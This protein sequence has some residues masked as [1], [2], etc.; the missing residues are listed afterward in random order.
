MTPFQKLKHFFAFRCYCSI[1][2]KQIL[3]SLL[4]LGGIYGLGLNFD[5]LSSISASTA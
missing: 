1:Q 4:N 2:D 3:E 5:L